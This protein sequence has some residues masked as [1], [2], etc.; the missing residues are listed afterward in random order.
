MSAYLSVEMHMSA[1][2]RRKSAGMSI[3]K[4][5]SAYLWVEVC[6]YVY[7]QKYVSISLGRNLLVC[8]CRCMSAQLCAEI[9][10][11][12]YLQKYVSISLGRNLLV[13]LSAEVCQHISGQESAVMSICRSTVGANRLER[14][15][16]IA[17]LKYL[18]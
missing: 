11:Y 12:V 13:C 17:I 3:C 1:Y 7:L 15:Y 4:S 14:S 10:W 5:M 16:L 9:C 2:L 18:K 8:L 6:W